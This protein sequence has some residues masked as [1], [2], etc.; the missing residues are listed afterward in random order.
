MQERIYKFRAWDKKEK[1]MYWVNKIDVPNFDSGAIKLE[2]NN[3]DPEK[4]EW[5]SLG[6][7]ELQQFTGLKDKNGKEIFEGDIVEFKYSP[8]GSFR[9]EIG[10]NDGGFWI[11]RKDGTNFMPSKEYREVIGNVFETPDIL[12]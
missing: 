12:K 10:F 5:Q 1:K 6:S 2:K 7:V 3:G 9:E 11:K 4:V 8:L